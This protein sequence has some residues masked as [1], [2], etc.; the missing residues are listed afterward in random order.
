[1]LNILSQKN[2]NVNHNQWVTKSDLRIGHVNIYYLLDK[3]TDYDYDL[4]SM[5]WHFENYQRF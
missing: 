5:F 1:M 3:L 4:E 2:M